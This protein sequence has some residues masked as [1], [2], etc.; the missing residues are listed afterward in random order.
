M[1]TNKSNIR[2]E[3]H[4]GNPITLRPKLLAKRLKL[5]YKHK[6]RSNKNKKMASCKS[7]LNAKT[8]TA[9]NVS[10]NVVIQNNLRLALNEITQLKEKINNL[11]TSLAKLSYL[12]MLNDPSV[13][14]NPNEMKK[15][16]TLIN[17]IAHEVTERLNRAKH[18]I[19]LNIP[20]NINTKVITCE[21]QRVLNIKDPS[22]SCHRL[23]RKS[24]RFPCPVIP[25]FSSASDADNIYRNQ[26]LLK[27]HPLFKNVIIRSDNTKRQCKSLFENDIT[28]IAAMQVVQANANSTSQIKHPD[29]NC[30]LDSYEEPV[31][32]SMKVNN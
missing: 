6:I 25:K 29:N 27:L 30:D 23:R 15:T 22:I 1:S 28:P 32:L 5:D 31:I 12:A 14:I 17:V 3:L 11:E 13:D 20:D 2:V 8:T 18:M 16:D 26:G 24:F 10:S 9:S 7:F 21:I 4:G 19:L